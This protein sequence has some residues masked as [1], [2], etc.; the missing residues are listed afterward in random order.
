[1]YLKTAEWVVHIVDPDQ[2]SHFAAA[3]FGL[4]CLSLFV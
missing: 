4:H 1:M 2:M 3:D